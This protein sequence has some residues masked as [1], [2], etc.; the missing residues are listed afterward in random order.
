LGGV[1]WLE[2]V[3]VLAA[4]VLVWAAAVLVWAAAWV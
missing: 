2:L 4:A 3:L 1:V